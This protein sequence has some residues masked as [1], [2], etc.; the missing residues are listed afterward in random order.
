ME[1]QSEIKASS[2]G[3]APEMS[4]MVAELVRSHLELWRQGSPAAPRLGRVY[5]LAEK[6]PRE[7]HLE[8][9]LDRSIAN[10]GGLS[11]APAAEEQRARVQDR[12]LAEG[13][14]I[15][16]SVFDILPEQLDALEQCRFGEA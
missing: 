16:I 1:S 5:S 12:L 15:A 6:L 9:F 13:R 14:E 10:L 3:G 7:R 8:D 4:E 11:A 2:A